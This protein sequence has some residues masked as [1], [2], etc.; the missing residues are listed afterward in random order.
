MSFAF[1]GRLCACLSSWQVKSR[2][3]TFDEWLG[4][5]CV[6]FSW[7]RKKKYF[8]S[9]QFPRCHPRCVGEWR[10]YWLRV[11]YFLESMDPAREYF[12]KV[13]LA[14]AKVGILMA[15]PFSVDVYDTAFWNIAFCE[16]PPLY[17]IH[18]Q[19]LNNAPQRNTT[20]L[21][22]SFGLTHSEVGFSTVNSVHP[23]LWSRSISSGI[24]MRPHRFRLLRFS[25]LMQQKQGYIFSG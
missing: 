9:A 11:F 19:Y 1:W 3:R 22:C 4:F 12:I 5:D 21:I 13:S 15:P 7:I 6:T 10:H 24:Q 8:A 2:N 17:C 18:F 25:W 23:P 14:S 20:F 16:T